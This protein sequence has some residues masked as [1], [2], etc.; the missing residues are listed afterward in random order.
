MAGIAIV[1]FA[2]R[3]FICK[4]GCTKGGEK[5]E[6]AAPPAAPSA[7]VDD[8]IGYSLSGGAMQ[9]RNAQPQQ[10]QQPEGAGV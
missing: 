9:V 10:P 6:E 5:E 8:G 4:R 2:I 1:A 3:W 7:A